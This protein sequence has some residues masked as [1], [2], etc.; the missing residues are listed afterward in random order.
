MDQTSLIRIEVWIGSFN[1]HTDRRIHQKQTAITEDKNWRIPSTTLTRLDLPW[2]AIAPIV[3]RH[4]KRYNLSQ[5]L[6]GNPI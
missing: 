2:K 5:S 6:P 1:R 4:V 3:P